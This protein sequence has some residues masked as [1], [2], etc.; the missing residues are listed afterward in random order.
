VNSA[1]VNFLSRKK[2]LAIPNLTQ[3]GRSGFNFSAF[4]NKAKASS[5]FPLQ[6]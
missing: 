1:K 6:K 2:Q 5:K 3:A 4:L